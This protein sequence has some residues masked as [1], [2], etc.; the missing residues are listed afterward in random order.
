MLR[1]LAL[2]LTSIATVLVVLGAVATAMPVWPLVLVDHFRV[3]LV[4]GG[5]LVI[6]VA[7][8]LRIPGY[9]DAAILATGVHVFALASDLCAA[10]SRMPAS[11]THVRVLVLNV[12]TE[13]RHYAEVK[14]L[15]ADTHPDVVG[16]V[17]VNRTWLTELAPALTGFAG[18]LEQPRDDNFGVA[19]YSR[20]PL[21]GAIE[22]LD[23][24]HELPVAIGLAEGLHIVLVHP[25]PP[26]SADAVR[27][28][29][30]VLAAV[31][32]RVLA[33]TLVIGDLNATPWSTPFRT[34]VVRGGLCDTRS[35]FGIQGSFPSSLPAILRI[36]IDHALVSCDVGVA[37]RH[38]ERPVGSDHLPVVVE[39]VVP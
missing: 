17:E 37:D 11:G 24:G 1:R 31:A 12:L 21:A 5:A 35:G 29:L 32:D 28:Q 18:R 16:L 2:A 15:I 3:Q 8:V 27:H 30:A 34:L 20:G 13:N 38:I 25:L 36:P 22:A 33:P 9:L 7:A 19:L 14:Q 6:A 10:P 39:L 23:P 26:M 4:L